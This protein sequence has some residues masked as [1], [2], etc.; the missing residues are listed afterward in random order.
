MRILKKAIICGFLTSLFILSGCQK[1]K[2]PEPTENSKKLMIVAHPDDE[3]IFGGKHLSEGA[4]FI[5]CLTNRDNSV[6]KAEFTAMLDSTKNEG[7][8]LDFPDKRF[9]KRDNWEHHKEK[10]KKL[11]THYV[12]SKD[13]ESIT[14]HNSEGEYGHIHHKMTHQFV[15]A[16]CE[17]NNLTDNLYYFAP[18]YKKQELNKHILAPM[19]DEDLKA[20]IKLTEIY[21]SQEKVCNNLKHI[22]PYEEWTSYKDTYK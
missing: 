15:T 10:I 21:L 18:Y 9:G 1:E 11:I 19:S 4:Y 16:V 2:I 3:T 12:E 8:I 20:K 7:V 17:K 13:W 14:T 6:R 22:F 5:V